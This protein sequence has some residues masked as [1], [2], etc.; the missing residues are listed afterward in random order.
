MSIKN[1]GWKRIA[2]VLVAVLLVAFCVGGVLLFMQLNQPPGKGAAA[3]EGYRLSQPV[4]DALEK[5]H[6]ARGD[7][8][9][10][11]PELIPTYLPQ[12]PERA[13]AFQLQYARVSATDYT[14][15]FSYAGPG[16]NHCTYK[17]QSKAWSCY[18]YY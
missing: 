4:I 17:G 12:L 8:P 7:Y 13:T 14:L 16:M 11:L 9:A 6:A 10:S 5:F 2:L 3:E 1:W 18:G 15:A